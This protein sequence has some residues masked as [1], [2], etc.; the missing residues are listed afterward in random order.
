MGWWGGDSQKE[1]G[2]KAWP[3]TPLTA[4]AEATQK[5]SARVF[6]CGACERIL[7][8]LDLVNEGLLVAPKV[9][10][11]Q[12]FLDLVWCLRNSLTLVACKVTSWIT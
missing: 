5:A 8:Y 7:P 11:V 4:V 9:F 6:L 3:A 10:G 1:V 12:A 2:Q